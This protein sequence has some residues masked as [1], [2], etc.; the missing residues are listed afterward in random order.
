MRLC[1]FQGTFNPIHKIHVAMAEFV[2]A[3]FDFDTILFIPAYKPP[4]KEIDDK[5]AHHR[6]NMVKLA[7]EGK[8]EF[9][10][11]DIEFESERFS[12]TYLTILE[13]Y[14]RYD[15]SGKINFIIGSDAFL[16]IE[17]WY[18]AHKLKHIVEFI[19]LGRGAD[20]SRE[21]LK[22]LKGQGFFYQDPRIRFKDVSSTQIREDIR[23]RK[24]VSEHL[25]PSVRE[26][27]KKHGLYKKG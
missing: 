26:Y 20:F 19:V 13:L 1:V 14:K 22:H 5:L 24:D 4:H 8:P 15:V 3:Q 7:L 11:S 18:E 6:F 10:I 12:Y 23:Y 9:Q 17:S 2:Q 27:I 16:N 21:E 25:L